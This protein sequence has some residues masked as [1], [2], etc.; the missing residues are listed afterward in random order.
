MRWLVVALAICTPA[1][2][3]AQ[4]LTRDTIPGKW[5]DP[6]LPENLP[7]L[8]YPG[9]A[10]ALDR[11][12]MEINTGRYKLGLI[13]L[14]KVGDASLAP[15]AILKATAL[16][17]TGRRPQ[18]IEVLSQPATADDPHVEIL[19][20]NLLADDGKLDEA[21]KL[22]QKHMAEHKD[23]IAGHFE[24]GKLAEERG[25]YDTA[26]D[27]YKWFVDEPQH[28]LD[29]ATQQSF[30]TDSA[31]DLT[32][33][34]RALDRWAT[35]NGAYQTSDSLNDT[36]L[37][38][39]IRAYDIV[40]REYIP[41]HIAAAEYYISHDNDQEAANEL[42]MV[43]Q[44]N[45]NST[46]AMELLGS[47]VLAQFDFD[48]AD[49]IIASIRR[50]DHNSLR[51]DLLEAR[52]L[53]HQRRP[54]DAEKPIARALAKQPNNI[55]ALGLQAAA[56]SLQ[57]HNDQCAAILKQIDA[58]NPHN[59]SAYQEVA[60]QLGA[61]RQYPRAAAM[62]KIAIERAPWWNSARNGLGL[63]YTQSGDED[64]ARATLEAAHSL[65]PFNLRTTNYLRLLDDL[66]S[67]AR[68]E[69][70]HFI[71]MYDAAR[72]PVIPEYFSDY[73][74]SVHS[75]VCS[76]FKHEPGV[77]TFIEV[78]PTHDAFSVR[79]TGSPWIGTVGA[80]TGR[81]IALVSP[82]AGKNTL[83]TFNWTQ[84][85]R[86]EYTH[87]VTLSLT[88]NRI[89]HWFTEGLAVWEEHSPLRWE[90]VP[91]LYHAVK[92]N[93]LF[94]M[95]NLTW[96]FVRPRKPTDRQLAYAQSFWICT[97][98]EEKYGHDA[99]LK[100]LDL[101]RQGLSQDEVFPKS[102]NRSIDQFYAEFVD[103]TKQ[104]IATWGYDEETSKKYT[105]LRDSAMDLVKSRQYDQA[106]DAWEQIVK[107]RPMDELP[108]QRLAGLYL[109]PAINQPE[110]AIEQLKIL[111][112]VE[113]KDNRLAKRIAVLYRDEGKLPE[114]Q[115]FALTAV[116]TDPYDKAAHELLAD[117]DQKAGDQKGLEREQKV[118]PILDHWLEENRRRQATGE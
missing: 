51:A 12:R 11:A 36:I 106:V 82:R 21:I 109:T 50:V 75:I 25:D 4:D 38:I 47:I 20:A 110:K 15:V 16:A 93:E 103:W 102:I 99:I 60:D 68:K 89:P 65:D 97:F 53:L 18:A 74:E 19:K 2:V 111:S 90:W 79:T 33:I 69:S 3:A 57:L 5:L 56:A 58:I 66:A 77:K 39:F 13:T 78:F 23:S 27:A 14:K 49:S 59:A 26:K 54:A 92:E 118:I 41:A 113:L 17:E 98:L 7:K 1:I 101:Y 100:M 115:K 105:E 45:P 86:H 112:A 9:Y 64:D 108:H 8:Q 104:Q 6:F 72:D 116:Y 95:D 22:V 10:T 96:A 43:L 55:E 70:P 80:S 46:K 44:L 52:N 67:F 31:E 30:H 84:V 85:L 32:Y 35:L 107:L 81:V 48:K 34:G 91:M 73:L 24:L 42:Q 29:R 76:D 62:Y 28:F 83:G 40:D 87:T 117:I 114:A 94:T 37:N 63:L 71:V 61:M 88:D